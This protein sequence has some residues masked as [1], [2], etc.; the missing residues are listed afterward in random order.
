MGLAD[1][2]RQGK[3]PEF[4]MSLPVPRTQYMDMHDYTLL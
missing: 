1:R 2:R 3:K 4:E